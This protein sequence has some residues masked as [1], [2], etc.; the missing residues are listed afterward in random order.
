MNFKKAEHLNKTA[1]IYNLLS[2]IDNLERGESIW[3]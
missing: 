2:N 1:Y 3:F